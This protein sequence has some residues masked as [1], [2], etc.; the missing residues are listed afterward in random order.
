M[1]TDTGTQFSEVGLNQLRQRV[2]HFA[3]ERDWQQFHTPRNLLLA[4]TGEVSGGSNH[5][6]SR[7]VQHVHTASPDASAYMQQVNESALADHTHSVFTWSCAHTPL[8][9]VTDPS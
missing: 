9:M 5:V 4:L 2:Q 1:S 3:I 6:R 8:H 7:L